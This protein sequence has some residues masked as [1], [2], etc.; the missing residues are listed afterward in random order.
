M[1][2]K[3]ASWSHRIFPAFAVTILCKYTD[4]VRFSEFY[5]RDLCLTLYNLLTESAFGTSDTSFEGQNFEIRIPPTIFTRNSSN[6]RLRLFSNS[7]SKVKKASAANNVPNAKK[8]YA[9]VPTSSNSSA[10]TVGVSAN[11]NLLTNS[12]AL[13]SLSMQYSTQTDPV[14]PVASSAGIPYCP[15][16]SIISAASLSSQ[17]S[18]L[19]VPMSILSRIAASSNQY[20]SNVPYSKST[21]PPKKQTTSSSFAPVRP[22]TPASVTTQP[23]V[24]YIDTKKMTEA[25][26][27][28]YNDFKIDSLI[29]PSKPKK[30]H[31]MLNH[32]SQYN[33]H[34]SHK[35]EKRKGGGNEKKEAYA[36]SKSPVNPSCSSSSNYNSSNHNGKLSHSSSTSSAVNCNSL[37]QAKAKSSDQVLDLSPN[38]VIKSESK[39]SNHGQSHPSNASSSSTSITVS[40][41]SYWSN[42]KKEVDK[43]EESRHDLAVATPVLVRITTDKCGAA[44]LDT[45][46]DVVFCCR[47]A[48]TVIKMRLQSR[49]I[50][51]ENSAYYRKASR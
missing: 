2:R 3:Y 28:K 6:N 36:L 42:S 16:L 27:S 4:F 37:E 38:K 9:P 32:I 47:R 14:Y 13:Q 34:Y 22:T 21:S 20:P 45:V 12:L 24:P 18:A 11:Y 35:G 39:V 17:P 30:E 8:A 7:R 23:S 50:S 26:S 15:D 29:N 40:D 48:R 44:G 5:L 1:S 33:K 46:T 41:H 10:T 43:K 51:A 49:H 19:P 31:H 25:P